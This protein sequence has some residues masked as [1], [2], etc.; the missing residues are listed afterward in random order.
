MGINSEI[1]KTQ[2]IYDCSWVISKAGLAGRPD[3]GKDSASFMQAF[4]G[5]FLDGRVVE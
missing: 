1:R 5:E 3:I 4:L 2:L